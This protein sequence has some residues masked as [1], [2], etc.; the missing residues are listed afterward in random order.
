MNAKQKLSPNTNAADLQIALDVGHSSIGWAVLQNSVAASPAANTSGVNIL[1]CGAVTFPANDCLAIDRRNKRRQRRNIRSRKQRIERMEI[2]LE[3]MGVAGIKQQH[4]QGK[5]NKQGEG[6]GFSFPWLL[7]ARLLAAPESE[8]QKH[9]L[10]WLQLWDVLRWY[11][12][13]RGY[14]GNLRW[15]GSYIVDGYSPENKLETGV[16]DDMVKKAKE[17]KIAEV[18]NSEKESKNKDEEDDSDKL[19]M[20]L[21]IMREYDFSTPTFAESVAKFLLGPDRSVKPPKKPGG[22]GDLVKTSERFTKE[23]F[24]HKLFGLAEE[25][26][27]HPKHLRN[28]FKGL[29]AAFPRRYFIPDT[30]ILAGGTEWEVRTIIRAHFNAPK[31]FAK[32][33][34]IFEQ[35]ICGAMPENPADWRAGEK[36]FPSL[37]LSASD[38]LKLRQ[39]RGANTDAEKDKQSKLAERKKITAGKILLPKRYQGGLLF[40]QLVPRFENRIIS[41]C[42]VTYGRKL[43]MLLRVIAGN[44]P[45]A[46]SEIWSSGDKE[47]IDREIAH[48]KKKLAKLPAT[49]SD[50]EK[51]IRARSFAADLAKTPS[52]NSLAFLEF[53]WAML[54]ANIKI[55]KPNIPFPKGETLRPLTAQERQDID[56]EVRKQGFLTYQREEREK[57]TAKLKKREINE[58]ADIIKG[59]TGCE[60][61][62]TNLDGFFIPPDMREALKLVPVEG[63]TK[64]FQFVWQHLDDKLRRRF[65]IQMLDGKEFTAG[66][67]C[68]Q[69]RTLAKKHS[70]TPPEKSPNEIAAIIE[71][72][73]KARTA[74]KKGKPDDEKFKKL[75]TAEFRC[76]LLEGRA[77]YHDQVLRQVREEVMRGEDPRK[78]SSDELF[79]LLAKMPKKQDGC[80]VINPEAQVLIDAK[81]LASQSNN[82]LVRHRIQVLAGNMQLKKNGD[83]RRDKAT[84]KIFPRNSLLDDILSEFANGDEKRIARITIEVTR[85]LQEM[86]GKDNEKKKQ[87]EGQKR[88]EHNYIANELAKWLVDEND[89]RIKVNGEPVKIGKYIKKAWIAND[90]KDSTGWRCPYTVAAGS[91]NPP[92]LEPIHLVFPLS[93]NAR[94]E[95]EHI[96]PKSKRV[97]N[98]MEAQ[99]ITFRAVNQW[100]GQRTGL[101][102]VKRHGGEFV[103]GL[104][105]RRVMKEDEYRAF[106]NGLSERGTTKQDTLRRKKRKELLLTEHWN[107]QDF[108]P[109]DLTN[110]AYVV[111]LAAE[112]L[113]AR[114]RHL[115]E[116]A[117]LVIYIP[118]SV[119]STFRDKTWKMFRQLSAVHPQVKAEIDKGEDRFTIGFDGEKRPDQTK[120]REEIE[121]GIPAAKEFFKKFA[122]ESFT[123]LE[124]A[125]KHKELDGLFQN[126]SRPELRRKVYWRKSSFNLKKAMREITHLH[127][128]VD[129]ATLGL[130]AYYLVPPQNGSLDGTLAKY[131]VKGSLNETERK[132]FRRIY[133]SLQLARNFWFQPERRLRFKGEDYEEQQENRE[134]FIGRCGDELR[135]LIDKDA[136]E[137][138]TPEERTRFESL[139][140]ELGL[141]DLFFFDT[142]NRL[143]IRDLRREVKTQLHLVFAE[144]MNQRIVQHVP[145]DMSVMSVKENIK[146]YKPIDEKWVEVWQQERDS[147]TGKLKIKKQ[148]IARDKLVGLEKESIKLAALK[149]VLEITENMAVALVKPSMDQ[150][151]PP[152]M[153][154]IPLH[155]AWKRLQKFRENNVGKHIILIRKG[156][157]IQFKAGLHSGKVWKVFGVDNPQ[158]EGPQ[159]KVAAADTVSLQDEPQL[160]YK[161]I[162]LRTR[163]NDVQLLQLPLTGIASCPTTSS[164]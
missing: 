97:A 6:K 146:G 155:G 33:D 21:T 100:K 131:I 23:D 65:T 132:D 95:L 48:F 69:L 116:N 72:D 64:A 139:V 59:I 49:S 31:G 15:S 96:I 154:V 42:P 67:I 113:R 163:W 130:V 29:K 91:N 89:E 102:F 24:H 55:N 157:L 61:G 120:T 27:D 104:P 92:I 18:E 28:Y 57:K 53:R 38:Q 148:K 45:Y 52:K 80:L 162:S 50:D 74:D 98:G 60:I 138:L 56:A 22:A 11:A 86:S 158:K 124:K 134:S 108:T 105:G 4:Q 36:Q 150:E 107:E 2:L 37:Y 106:V 16:L 144:A 12:H 101:E 127:H 82:H 135:A 141:P 63:E 114:F 122:K 41:E 117:P 153:L 62:D 87:I 71:T 112:K 121:T 152:P 20:G 94:L 77:R 70:V 10:T 25:Y 84:G 156:A 47:Q 39:L 73:A 140:E 161:R 115:K 123:E 8:R 110:T 88:S 83:I 103:P 75:M 34:E 151:D 159:L 129:A 147:V 81:P 160:N 111:K 68:E 136:R 40:G 13:N 109:G 118:G 1:G 19:A 14:D 51:I 9:L 44:E 32:C 90:L 35:I 128:A 66:L 5:G 119:T 126:S 78:K 142:K 30:K 58:L 76:K 17:L 43:P 164:A 46:A 93:D 26:R 54:L 99:V 133:Y 137:R 125:A 85:D 149:G 145:A 3:A 143:F 7:A 79:L